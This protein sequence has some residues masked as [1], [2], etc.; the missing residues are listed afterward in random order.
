[1]ILSPGETSSF[2]GG[3]HLIRLPAAVWK[4]DTNIL[5]TIGEDNGIENNR[6]AGIQLPA[7]D[8][9]LVKPIKGPN[10]IDH[11][12]A[13]TLRTP[14]ARWLNSSFICSALKPG[15]GKECND[16]GNK[17]ELNLSE[18]DWPGLSPSFIYG[19]SKLPNEFKDLGWLEANGDEFL[20]AATLA[21]KHRFNCVA[22]SGPTLFEYPFE[23]SCLP[24][25]SDQATVGMSNYHQLIYFD[26]GTFR[27]LAHKFVDV[28]KFADNSFEESGA[29][30]LTPKKSV[31]CQG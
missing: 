10:D 18:C 29:S 14:N 6:T 7:M 27:R 26:Q 23:V 15:L 13:Y 3:A 20:A 5:V 30:K 1:M 16:N 19:N 11:D 28:K 8:P 22:L 24:A 4:P 25:Q 31:F 12:I 21:C 9:F 17:T 2:Q